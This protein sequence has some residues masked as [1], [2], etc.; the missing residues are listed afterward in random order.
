MLAMKKLIKVV[1]ELE[2]MG[3]PWERFDNFMLAAANC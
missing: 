2:T 1:I 3:W